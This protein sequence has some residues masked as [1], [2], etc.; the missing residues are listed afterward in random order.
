L[1][2]A[3]WALALEQTLG[4]GSLMVVGPQN[5]S[6]SP[7]LHASVEGRA[8]I[9]PAQLRLPGGRMPHDF[10]RLDAAGG[11][12][13]AKRFETVRPAL[14]LEAVGADLP[15]ERKRADLLI[16]MD[17]RRD[18]IAWRAKL[19][20]YDHFLTGWSAHLRRYDRDGTT[21]FVVFVCRDRSR[22]REC[23]RRADGLLGASRAYAGERPKEWE[24]TGREHILFA[25]E[26]DVHERLLG[27]YAVQGVPPQARVGESGREQAREPAIET[28]SM[29]RI[30]GLERS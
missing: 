26:R 6:I 5:A 14:I 25:A 28:R 7:P 22:A 30:L 13:E 15:A 2:V 17:D 12:A 4:M 10:Q 1:H 3:G 19:V 20:R 24:Y 16:E 23:A 18:A 9:G 8:A 29:A 21:P 27:T 11:R